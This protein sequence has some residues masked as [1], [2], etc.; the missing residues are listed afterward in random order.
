[1]KKILVLICLL[2]FAQAAWA[3]DLPQGD[4]VPGNSVHQP[5][6]QPKIKLTTGTSE[7]M[8]AYDTEPV[9]Y[10][11]GLDSVNAEWAVRFTPPQACSLSYFELAT[12]SETG[13]PGQVAITLYDGDSASGPQNALGSTVAFTATGDASFQRIELDQPLD[14]GT[15]DFFI[16]IKV[17][18][19]NSPHLTGDGDGGTGRSWYRGPVQAWDW[20]EDV[21]INIRAYVILYGEDVSAPVILHYPDPA[22]Y[23]GDGQTTIYAAATDASGIQ[24]INLRYSTNGGASYSSVPM[25]L[26]GELYRATVPIQMPSTI[27][28]YY[29]EATD[30]SPAHNQGTDPLGG[31]A[32]PYQYETRLG[33][34]LK[35]DNGWPGYFLI[36]SEIWD[37]NAF[38]VLFTPTTFPITIS[39]LRVFVS[40]VADFKISVYTAG[41]PQPGS[42]MAGP[43][44]VSASVAP[45]WVDIDI[46]EISQPVIS[47][48]HFFVVFEWL[49]STPL[50]PGVG[51]D[52]LNVDG[53]S[54]W[55]DNANGWV[56]WS[57]ADW[58]I[59][60]VYNTAVGITGAEDATP[61]QE[62]ALAQ[63][64][65]NP[66]N[67][68]TTIEYVLK[69]PGNVSL[70]IFNTLGRQVRHY[71]LG[72]QESGSHLALW[73]GRDEQ[74]RPAPSGIYYYRLKAGD[75]AQARKM[76]LMK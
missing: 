41:T 8:L 21:D 23:A 76:V 18:D 9:W 7:F 58:M 44:T 53:R 32:T 63:N 52:T 60:A 49:P 45:G 42:I 57:Y 69:T 66:F 20:V 29:F 10:F 56:S 13:M 74:N 25:S 24:S 65:P 4:R 14:V 30:V 64:Y 67:P 40:E 70:E 37:G 17:I 31:A 22:Y 47:A 71:D 55:Y 15:D 36:V 6:Q 33:R 5:P 11:A 59:R 43:F 35:Y 51:A 28:Q 3:L 72:W 54:M 50:V 75:H 39:Q 68:S 38:A 19:V 34:Q 62:F 73:N 46:P 12:F 61:P 1:M 26:S 16:A 27:V 48:G 2:S